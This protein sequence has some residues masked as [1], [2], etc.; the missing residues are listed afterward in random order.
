MNPKPSFDE[1]WNRI[2]AHKGEKFS[3]LKGLE[4]AYSMMG[5]WL[6]VSRTDFRI[7][8]KNIKNAYDLMPVTGPE[9]FPQEIQVPYYVY[10]ILTDPRIEVQ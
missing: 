1:I 5:V 3:T 2:R 9:E 8:K 10:A 4:F 7:T 6:V